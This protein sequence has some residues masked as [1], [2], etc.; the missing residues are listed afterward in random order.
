MT[1]QRLKGEV[2]LITGASRGIGAAICDTLAAHGAAVVGTATSASGAAAITERLQTAGVIGSGMQLDVTDPD[3]SQACVAA[4]VEQF[5]P[6][7]ILVNNAGITQ[8]NL[9]MRMKDDEWNNVISTNL[10]SV[11]RMCKLVIK[12]MVKARK[13]RIIN[14]SS[15]VGIT[16][17]AGQVNYAAS[18][19]GM[20]GMTRS[21]ARELGARSITVNAI[22]PG[23]I[24]SDMTDA[25]AD[26]QKEKLK[27]EIALGRLGN[28][29]DIAKTCLFLVSDDAEYITGQTIS[30]NGGMFMS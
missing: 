16:G 11:F 9:F 10:S 7:S 24:E 18:K 23:F 21:L 27:A 30:V 26:E 22:A 28:P 13:G 20:L 3:A 2:A 12:P 15:V 4:V 1:E 6:V 5:G 25:L 17:N 19:A 14:I 29:A 8:D